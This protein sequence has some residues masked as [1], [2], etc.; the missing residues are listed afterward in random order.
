LR[1]LSI[2]ASTAPKSPFVGVTFR[3]I[4]ADG[5]HVGFAWRDGKELWVLNQHGHLK[6]RRDPPDPLD[7]VVQLKLPS[8]RVEPT[9]RCAKRVEQSVKGRL[10]YNFQYPNA[11]FDQKT[12]PAPATR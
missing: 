1:G 8:A 7:A 3:R 11:I 5:G 4:G 10:P 9:I 2:P 12:G 6:L